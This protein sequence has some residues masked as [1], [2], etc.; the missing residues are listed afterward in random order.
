[1]DLLVGSAQGILTI[2]LLG[3]IPDSGVPDL[4]ADPKK[5]IQLSWGPLAKLHDTSIRVQSWGG[6]YFL[7]P[8]GGSGGVLYLVNPLRCQARAMMHSNLGT[9]L[10]SPAFCQHWNRKS[11]VSLEV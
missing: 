11:I 2:S 4:E 8:S 3:M 9:V 1:M 10:E 5:Y 7:D 6:F